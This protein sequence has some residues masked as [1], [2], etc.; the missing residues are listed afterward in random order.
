MK[1]SFKSVGDKF[2]GATLDLE[3]Q[4]VPTFIALAI[5]SDSS[6]PMH[7]KSLSIP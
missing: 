6:N 2:L 7:H 5:I 3:E 1:F 4:R